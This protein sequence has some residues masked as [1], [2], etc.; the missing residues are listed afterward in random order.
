MADG[1]CPNCECNKFR[2]AS[3]A[4]EPKEQLY[5]CAYCEEIFDFYDSKI[6]EETANG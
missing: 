5:Q 3:A 1:E 4:I 2:V 6:D